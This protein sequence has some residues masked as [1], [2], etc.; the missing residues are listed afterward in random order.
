MKIKNKSALIIAILIPI[1]VGTLSALFSG[2][3]SLYS[4]INKP[5]ISPPGYIFP[6][7][8][9]ILYILMGISSYLIYE[10]DNSN[11]RNALRTYAL[12]LFF[13]FWWSIIF[14][15]F[16]LYLF[17]FLWLLALIALIAIM[18]YQFYQINQLSSY[19]QIPYLLW[20][21]FAAY[22]NFMIYRLN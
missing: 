8:W 15:R 4:T 13:N 12:Q 3:M 7:V 6:I 19:L 10:S 20:C 16:S 1:A 21:L 9:I 17:S 2:R 18:I 22:L 11:T 5:Q 14:F